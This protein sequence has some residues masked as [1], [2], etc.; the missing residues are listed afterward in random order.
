MDAGD[1]A[2]LDGLGQARLVADGTCTPSELVEAA[3][4]RIE[5]VNPQLNAVIVPLFERALAEA[6]GP[7]PDGP[8]RGVP[9]LLKDL[10]CHVAGMT[11]F[12]GTRFLRDRKWTSRSDSF[13]AERFRA[14][15]FVF[16]GKTNTPE[17]GLSPTTEPDTFGPTRNPWDHGA[18]RRRLERRLGFGGGSGARRRWRTR[19]TAAAPSA[20]RRVPAGWWG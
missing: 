14:A 12:G 17:L 5:R 1:L 2:K 15:G 8:Y 9:L 3:I 16:V 13:L 18:H 20:T 6:A 7:L 10:G 4:E 19:A 11:V